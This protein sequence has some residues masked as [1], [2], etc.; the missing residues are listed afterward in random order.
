MGQKVLKS[1]NILL[2]IFL[3]KS[4]SQYLKKDIMMFLVSTTKKT[5]PNIN[6]SHVPL[7]IS[8]LNKMPRKSLFYYETLMQNNLS[9]EL[10]IKEHY[11]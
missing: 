11:Q 4:L 5:I 8:I 3:P 1:T 2:Q 6:K 10:E 7:S 9:R